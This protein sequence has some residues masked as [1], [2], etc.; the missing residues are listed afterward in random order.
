M[1]EIETSVP[2]PTKARRIYPFGSM[3]VGDSFFVPEGSVSI[4]GSAAR[5]WAARQAPDVEFRCRTLTAN[6]VKGVRCWRAT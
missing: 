1:F 3:N 4:I 2:V 6:G 5:Q